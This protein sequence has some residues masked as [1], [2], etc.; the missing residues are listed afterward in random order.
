M[1][2]V[3]YYNF[4]K[5]GNFAKDFKKAKVKDYNYYKTKMFL[6][7]K[8]SD[9]QVLLA[10]DQVWM[11]SSRKSDQELSANMVSIA[12]MERFFFIQ[13]KDHHFTKKLLGRYLITPL[14][15]KMNLNLIN[16]CII[17]MKAKVK[18]YNYY[19]T[20][21]FLIKKDSDQ[22]VLLAKDQVWM[23]S[24]R[25]SDQELSANMVSMAKMEKIL[26][27]SEERPTFYK[28]TLEEV[29]YYSSDSEN[30]SEF[31]QPSYYYDEVYHNESQNK[32]H[33]VYKLIV[34]FTQKIAKCHK[35][36]EK[37]NQQSKDLETQNK[38]LQEK[39]DVLNNQ[40]NTFEDKSKEF[41]VQIEELKENNDDLLAHTKT[42]EEQLKVK[43]VKINTHTK[44]QA[45]YAKL[46]EEKQQ[47][48]IKF[49]S[50]VDNDR[51]QLQK[52]DAQEILYNKMSCQ[53]VEINNNVVKLK[54]NI[55]EKQILELEECV[56]KK[57]LA[58]EKAVEDFV[59]LSFLD[60]SKLYFF[61]YEHVAVNSTRY[62]LDATAIGKP[63]LG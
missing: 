7:K 2:K 54:E 30:E 52:I 33:L 18:D 27:Y 13:R 23:E 43:H 16:L 35:C 42:L 15:L 44:C 4:K 49:S 10:K 56:C 8:D 55:L 47:H 58:I 3:R 63:A 50:L 20:K 26:F 61:E 24:S 62:G 34:N 48:M 17:I 1:I 31:D 53:L 12:K 38:V 32:D 40:V 41:D 57:D 11:E 19:K 22:Q 6:I 45:Q 51:Q 39:Y 60:Y 21:M 29:S 9:Q 46:K 36:I 59:T 25:K 14:I 5:E 37:A 28:E